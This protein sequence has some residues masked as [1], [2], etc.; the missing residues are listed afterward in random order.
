MGVAER[1]RV[2]GADGR[3]PRREA[4]EG[5]YVYCSI[6]CDSPRRLGPI[7]I[8]G[9][10]DGVSTI[11]PRGPAAVVSDTPV[12]VYGPTRENALT[13][14]H[15]NE[16]VMEEF[17]VIPMNSGSVFRTDKDLV[18]FLKDTRNALLDV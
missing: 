6:E 7:G 15:I 1:V 10:G 13:H 9:C 12:V 18:E 16:A 17:T 8:G 4:E 11:H 14:E 2:P 3:P 5:K